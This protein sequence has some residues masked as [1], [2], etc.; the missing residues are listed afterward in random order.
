MNHISA[1]LEDSSF[2][3]LG[4]SSPF[5]CMNMPNVIHRGLYPAQ[6]R[7]VPLTCLQDVSSLSKEDLGRALKV[8]WLQLRLSQITHKCWILLGGSAWEKETYSDRGLHWGCRQR[9]ISLDCAGCIWRATA[10]RPP[11]RAT[12]VLIPPRSQQLSLSS[13]S[14]FTRP[15][16]QTPLS[17][18][19]SLLPGC[20]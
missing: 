14:G 11:T 3:S 10:L 20:G 5:V 15:L 19:L 6:G 13:R 9:P 8:L 2:F 12:K 7:Q 1:N 4:V 16:G 18:L 17:A